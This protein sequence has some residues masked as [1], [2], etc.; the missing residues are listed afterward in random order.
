MNKKTLKDIN[1]ENKKVIVRFDFNVPISDGTITDDKRIKAT[2]ATIKYLQDHNAKIIMLSH[3]GRVKTEED[4]QKKTLAPI[5]KK[6]A[7][8]ANYP[9]TFI[10]ETRGKKLE[11]AINN[12]KAKDLLLIE[13][14]RFEDLNGKKE[15]GND[16]ELGTYWASLAEVFVNDAFGTAHRA[17][18]SNVGIATYI[19]D[20]CVGF[21]IEKELTMLNKIVLNPSRPFVAVLGGAKVSDKIDVIKQLLNKADTVIIGGAMAYT[22]MKALGYS[23]GNSL[24]ENDKIDL[25]KELIEL[26]K[27]KLV[28]PIDYVTVSEFKDIPGTNTK[29]CNIADNQMGLDIGIETVKLF[30][31]KLQTAKTVFWN[32]PVGVFEMNNFA[33]GTEAICETIAN[34][35]D[36]FTLVGGGDSAAAV[37]KFHYEDKVSFISTGGGA[38]LEY[39]EGKPLP[40]IE[41]IKNKL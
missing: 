6:L 9:V 4:K 34:L 20:S 35:K 31:A 18:A 28:L 23:I 39:V 41:A 32:G 29:D 38:S 2:L 33:R 12:L 25:A 15:S 1:F 22:F 17:H 24:V 40:G 8:L 11:A 30:N 26:G 3:L 21:L 16:P 27:E 36:A 10:D 19:G 14:T 13:N 5:A 37:G 7:E